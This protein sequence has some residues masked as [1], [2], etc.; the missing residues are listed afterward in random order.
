MVTELIEYQK[1]GLDILRTISIYELLI[2][3]CK[4]LMKISESNDLNCD[5]LIHK[6]EIYTKCIKRLFERYERSQ[7]II[8]T[9]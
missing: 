2:K 9:Y 8:K 1:K 7:Q 5:H 6:I 4:K 3:T